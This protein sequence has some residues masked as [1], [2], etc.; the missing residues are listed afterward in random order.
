MTYQTLL[1]DQSEGITTLTLNRPEVLN[2]LSPQLVQEL[3]QA[4]AQVAMDRS[5]RVLVVRGAGRAWSAGVDLKALQAGI[6]EGQ[7]TEAG[8]LEDGLALIR[9][10]QTMPQATIAQVHGHV[11]TGALELMMAFD[12]VVAASDTRLGDTHAKWGILPKWGMTQRLPRLVGLRKAKEMSFAAQAITGEEAARL[13]LVNRAVASEE[14]ETTVA[15]FCTA[16]CANSAQTIAA[17]KQL[18]HQGWQGTLARGLQ[19][20]LDWETPVSDRGDFLRDFEQHK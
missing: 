7:F 6:Q 9:D 19:G 13:G 17:M 10:L 11:Y 1:L 20:E 18:Y 8:I 5:I 4:V 16:I 2:A 3:R 12:L 14:L 15:E